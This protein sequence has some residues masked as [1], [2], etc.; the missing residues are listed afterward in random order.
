MAKRGQL[1]VIAGFSGTGKGTV[2]KELL[3]RD[4]KILSISAT[5]RA[6]RPEDAEGVTYFFKTV[7]EFKSMI[8]DE[9]LLEWAEFCG[10][11][12]GTP[13]KYVDDQLE[14]GND[15]IL[16]LE[17]EGAKNI[18]KIYGGDVTLIYILPPSA[19]ELKRRLV[20]R[21]ESEEFIIK[22]MTK[23]KTE[24]GRIDIFDYVIINDVVETSVD[25]IEQII[26]ASK[27][28]YRNHEELIKSFKE[29]IENEIHN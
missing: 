24:S 10:N 5:T 4:K 22:R 27:N 25:M 7:D 13:K 16:E 1:V 8:N 29:D 11:Y 15:V 3:K 2:I 18:K 21:G 14:I 28:K 19:K 6:M 9:L 23:A 26:E 12:Y 17:I 20:G